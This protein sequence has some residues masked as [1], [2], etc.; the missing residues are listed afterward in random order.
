[1]KR[2]R[3][4]DVMPGCEVA[5]AGDEQGILREVAIHAQRAHGIDALPSE[6]VEAVRAAIVPDPRPAT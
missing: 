3:C 1:M 4:G 5:F 6:A 2:F